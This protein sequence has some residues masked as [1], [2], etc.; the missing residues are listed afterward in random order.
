ARAMNTPIPEESRG[1]VPPAAVSFSALRRCANARG[2]RNRRTSFPSQRRLRALRAT[3]T[4]GRLGPPARP[5]SQTLSLRQRKP[6]AIRT[7]G[8]EISNE[9]SVPRRLHEPAHLRR[10]AA[11]RALVPLLPG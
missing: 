4:A 7:A 1:D 3:R 2:Q 11:L 10:I 6:R 8:G 5:Q 9:E